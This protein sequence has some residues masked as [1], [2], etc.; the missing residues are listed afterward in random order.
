VN[1]HGTHAYMHV[2]VHVE[3]QDWCQASSVALPFIHRGRVSQSNP[4]LAA[5]ARLTGQL[6]MSFVG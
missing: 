6:A 5:M 2:Q 1:G 3:A 4:E